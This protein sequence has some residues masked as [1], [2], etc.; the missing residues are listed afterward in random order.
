MTNVC[1]YVACSLLSHVSVPLQKAV[2]VLHA[3]MAQPDI[4]FFAPPAAV[5]P[6]ILFGA[7]SASPTLTAT[8]TLYLDG[9]MMKGKGMEVRATSTSST[10]TAVVSN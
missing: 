7:E 9:E 4:T 1:L 5:I 6:L 2:R 10:A 8:V 3:C